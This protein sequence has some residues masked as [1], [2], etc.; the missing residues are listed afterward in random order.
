M[1]DDAGRMIVRAAKAA[2]GGFVIRMAA[3]LLFLLMAAR[4]F[5]PAAFGA[6]LVALAIVELAV[7]LSS[8]GARKT[9]FHL[10]DG[11]D[12]AGERPAAH[13][14][15][16][17]ALLV[18]G[19]SAIALVLLAGLSPL[20]GLPAL[21][22]LAPAAIC[23]ALFEVLLAG[24][25]WKH[26]S[27][28]ELVARSIVE[29]WAGMA[30]T[31]IAW[32]LG[33]RGA[34]GLVLGY[35]AGALSTLLYSVF[36]A[37]TAF[38]G[39]G[40]ASYRPARDAMSA[41]LRL[42]PSNCTNDFLNALQTRA[43]LYLVSILLG[44]GP[45]G[46]YAAARQLVIPL[47]QVRQ[48][49]DSLLIPLVARTLRLRGASATGPALASAS[50]LILV[51]SLPLLLIL[52]VSGEELLALLGRAFEAAYVPL[53][54]YALAETIHACLGVGD[55]V[56]VY[57][58]PRLGLQIALLSSAFGIAAALLLIPPLGI[59]G[60]ALSV[61]IAYL[62]RA[63]LRSRALRSFDVA[64]TA[65]H[66]A[67]VA[68]A[69]AAAAAGTALARL[70]LPIAAP[71]AALAVYGLGILLWLR[72]GGGTLALAGFSHQRAPAAAPADPATVPPQP[73]EL[74][75]SANSD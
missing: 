32:L 20:V 27:R 42:A 71:A 54:V 31:A 57:L 50:R 60:A 47:R 49:F 24:T 4:L 69:L 25:R 72:H 64:T 10:L 56:F 2:G 63:G 65:G 28:D 9:L 62:L 40:L 58:R 11:V 43:D 1:S 75:R 70:D 46:L 26:R 66:A 59:A 7:T 44:D 55:L 17:A 21:L 38:G 33:W 23:L 6:Y 14:L 29:P 15:L 68:I 8:L 36:A 3:R 51:C 39:F 13:A 41:L 19:V 45:S 18:A 12:S 73:R 61:L 16:D 35:W 34:E 67:P 74:A 37:R 53:V 5:G 30:G 22:W 48:S 52:L